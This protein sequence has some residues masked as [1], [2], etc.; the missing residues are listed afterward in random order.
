MGITFRAIP[1]YTFLMELSDDKRR[2]YAAS[3]MIAP[4]NMC[5]LKCGLECTKK[6]QFVS[7]LEKS[8]SE[9]QDDEKAA[10]YGI[11]YTILPSLYKLSY[12]MLV[13]LNT[14]VTSPMR[15]I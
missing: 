2:V 6:S 7:Q 14:P 3:S 8:I 13:S 5:R 11:S 12:S 9:L 1:R 4:W 15:R 10:N